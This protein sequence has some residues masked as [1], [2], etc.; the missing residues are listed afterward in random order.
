MAIWIYMDC[1][2]WYPPPPQKKK[3]SLLCPQRKTAGLLEY[4]KSIQINPNQ[5]KTQVYWCPGISYSPIISK[6]H[7]KGKI[8]ETHLWTDRHQGFSIAIMLR[9]G[10]HGNRCLSYQCLDGAQHLSHGIDDHP[11]FVCCDWPMSWVLNSLDNGTLKM[12]SIG[13]QN[14]TKHDTFGSLNK[15]DRVVWLN[16]SDFFV[17]GSCALQVWQSIT[18]LICSIRV[19]IRQFP[20]TESRDY[21]VEARSAL[22]KCAPHEIAIMCKLSCDGLKK[23]KTTISLA[24]VVL[25]YF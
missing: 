22:R 12:W 16:W 10:P 25:G 19:K 13:W 7:R 18:M 23:N 4:P 20:S 3:I 17:A 11:R 2:T 24:S 14:N 9:L 1:W 8:N 15:G 5:S 6:T 21:R